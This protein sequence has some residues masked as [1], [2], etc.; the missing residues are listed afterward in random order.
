M[1]KKRTQGK[2][3][4][5]QQGEIIGLL[6]WGYPRAFI[7]KRF[8]EKYDFDLTPK[9]YNWWRKKVEDEADERATKAIERWEKRIFEKYLSQREVRLDILMNQ[10][11]KALEMVCED[12]LDFQRVN[13]E[14]RETLKQIAQELQEWHTGDT[15]N[16][17][18]NIVTPVFEVLALWATRHI[19]EGDARLVALDD[20]RRITQT[21]LKELPEGKTIKARARAK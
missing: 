21:F 3:T 2:L 10:A 5:E 13:K 17:V 15:Y 11:N 7:F 12:P 9:I 1:A 14:V 8:K 20:L 18:Y 19:P 16:I 6:Y 4:K